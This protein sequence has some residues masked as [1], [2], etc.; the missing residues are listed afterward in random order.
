MH[1][2]FHVVFGY[3][4]LVCDC[5][6]VFYKLCGKTYTR[7]DVYGKCDCVVIARENYIHG[8]MYI[9]KK[10]WNAKVRNHNLRGSE[11]EMNMK[12]L[13]FK[14]KKS[15]LQLAPLRKR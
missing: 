6:I 13:N 8:I 2:V 1:G 3:V 12:V 7:Y 15:G 14:E 10:K 11:N 5:V 4:F 9:G